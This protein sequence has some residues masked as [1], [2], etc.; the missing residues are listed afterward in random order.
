MGA[1]LGRL[2][3]VHHGVAHEMQQGVS[4]PHEHRAIDL[5][6][7]AGHPE[8]HELVLL[9]GGVA[10]ALA[11]ALEERHQGHESQIFDRPSTAWPTMA[12]WASSMRASRHTDCK[13]PKKSPH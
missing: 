8:A 3:S 1:L 4:K 11:E 6:S 5:G 2:E 10:H 12:D 9:S 13:P 7:V